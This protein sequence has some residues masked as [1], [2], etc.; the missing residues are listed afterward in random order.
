VH[1]LS[2]GRITARILPLGGIVQSLLVPDAHR[3]VDNVTLG[4][5]APEAYQ[6]PHPYFGA[7]IGRFANRIAG[8]R[9]RLDGEPIEVPLSDGPNSL[10]G[11]PHGFDKCTWDVAASDART[12]L[13]A[14][15]SRDGEEGYPGTLN[16]DVTYTVTDD[17]ALRLDYKATTDR[18]TVVNL[19]NHT[20]FNLAG[21]GSGHVYDHV[22]WLNADAY[23]PVSATLIPTGA[24]EAVDGTPFDFRTPTAIGARIRDAHA[25]LGYGRGYDHNFVL[26][27]WDGTVQLQA[28][29]LEPSSGRVLEVWTTEPGIQF[30]TGNLL[31]GTL[32]GSRG[33]RYRSGD[34]FTLETQHFP[35]SPNQPDFPST[36]LR[37][38][39][40]YRSTTI[41]R[42]TTVR[43]PSSPES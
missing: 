28:R 31:D 18:T 40:T 30:Y 17:D 11:G 7:L 10:H 4:F 27:N 5:A 21:E 39:E 3:Q 37:P 8:G 13:L 23:T 14:Y 32:V 6:Q 12:L 24:I 33:A 41:Y 25:Q 22:V 9:F 29:V 36:V 16:V 15:V 42:F 19:T 35:D 43:Q 38:G 34:A 1:S 20:Y 26:N 2:N